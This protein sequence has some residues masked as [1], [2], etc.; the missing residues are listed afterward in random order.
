MFAGDAPLGSSALLR[1]AGLPIRYWLAGASSTLFAKV[2]QLERHEQGRRARGIDL[3]ERIGEQLV[4]QPALSRDDRAFLLAVR[5]SLHRGDPIGNVSRE[6][7]LRVSGS[8]EGDEELLQA[9]AA[10]V[11]RDR[12]IGQLSAAVEADLAQEHNRLLILSQQISRE[13]RV[14]AALLAPQDPDDSRLETLSRK[15]RRHRSEH[16]WR[17]IARA[18]TSSTPRGWLSHV[19]LLAIEAQESLQP[20]AV[21]NRFTAQWAENVRAP[22]LALTN[23]PDDWPASETRLAVNPLRW[24]GDGRVVCVVVDKNREQTQVSV[25]QT[26]LLD[27]IL[28]ALKATA[29][30]F[31]ELGKSVGCAN[32]DEW[33][34]LRAFVRHLVILGIVQPSAPPLVRLE[35]Q[36]TP[37]QTFA[38]V[39]SADGDHAGWVDVYR[40][41]ETGISANFVRDVQRGVSQ[42]LRLLSVMR[43]DIADP[44][45][46]PVP[47]SVRSWSLSEILR[48]DLAI[49]DKPSPGSEGTDA[50]KGTPPA[51]SNARFA[52][53]VRELVEQAGQAPEV[54]IDSDRLDAW[55]AGNGA[56]HWPVDCLVRVPAPGAGFTAVLEDSRPPGVL[57]ARFADTLSDVHGVIP[58]V[59]AYRAFLHRLE[60][61]T[62]MLFV[63]LLVPP[64][65]DGAA[66]AVRRPIYTSAWT[67]DPHADGYL[68]GGT[69]AGTYIPLNEIAIRRVDG[70]LRAEVRGRPIWPVYHA[71]R[72]FEHPWSRVARVLLAAAP[73]DLTAPAERMTHMLSVLPAL[74]ADRVMVPRI[75]VS[76]GL[77][78][79][80][81]QW[82]LPPDQLWDRDASGQ[83]KL[84]ALIRLR[85]RYA[86][87]RW[88]YLRRDGHKS[89]VPCDFE[90]LH[91]FRTVERCTT[92]SAPLQIVEMLP[93]PDQLLVVDRAHRSGDRLA[94][95]LQLRFPCDE[96]ATAMAN[97]IAPAVLA[98]LGSP[99]PLPERLVAR[100]HP[101]VRHRRTTNTQATAY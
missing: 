90:S 49:D 5:R 92:G 1:V 42:A 74:P 87:P 65:T 36:A 81:A 40:Y 69:G 72:T 35:R 3:A 32:R 75:S 29:H 56:L 68:R 24:E 10:I 34:A 37:G 61:L 20:P 26:P 6:H 76:A 66:N 62:G 67:G 79:S 11:D 39:A 98:A 100:R 73:V 53:L 2:E 16:E 41:A 28:A 94:S 63:E 15:S 58:Q 21:T 46:W 95:Q 97:R 57:D 43:S 82:R 33:L 91:V 84:R 45:P 31:G 52:A 19:A 50:A 77:V 8:S 25:Q 85:D 93:A 55:G 14:A 30:T 80:P 60:Q 7:L 83:A 22:R 88:V 86:L 23:P 89:A 54:V 78:L 4:P 9:L 17:R 27:G 48:D 38:D 44:A 47:T 18:A 12:T 96:S 59:E 101:A 99:G 51:L 71:T 70:R 13:S 64:L